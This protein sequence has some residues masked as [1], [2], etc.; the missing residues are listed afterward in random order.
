MCFTLSMFHSSNPSR[1]KETR[2]DSHR[3]VQEGTEEKERRK[4]LDAT[5]WSLENKGSGRLVSTVSSLVWDFNENQ[6]PTM[7]IENTVVDTLDK[8]FVNIDLWEEK[9]EDVQKDQSRELFA[10]GVVGE[11]RGKL[12]P[13]KEVPKKFEPVSEEQL[14]REAESLKVEIE[15]KLKETTTPEVDVV[16]ANLQR[17]EINQTCKSPIWIHNCLL[18]L[19]V[20][21]QLQHLLHVNTRQNLLQLR[22]TLKQGHTSQ[23]KYRLRVLSPRE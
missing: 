22:S 15:R 18:L 16:T 12:P 19:N 2:E 9:S 3:L 7:G 14:M 6:D 1:D 17:M 5:Y 8:R 23:K 11:V 21:L 4:F 20:Q 13:K 10:E